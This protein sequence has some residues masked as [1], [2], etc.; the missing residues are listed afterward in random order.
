MN[1]HIVGCGDAGLGPQEQLEVFHVLEA[2]ERRGIEQQEDHKRD[3]VESSHS[4]QI[5]A[6]EG[7]R[8][9][10][11]WSKAKWDQFMAIE[12]CDEECGTRVEESGVQWEGV[13]GSACAL[14]SRLGGPGTA[15]WCSDRVMQEFK[16]CKQIHGWHP[17]GSDH[18][19]LLG[20]VVVVMIVLEAG[21]PPSP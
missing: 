15:V 18:L 3:F 7:R 10:E 1:G 8:D 2:A 12:V 20:I 17:F 13:R 6:L 21:V 14:M 5:K 9:L 11:S 19:D 4:I 16:D